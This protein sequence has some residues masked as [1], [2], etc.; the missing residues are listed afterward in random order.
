MSP[1]LATGWIIC[2]RSCRPSGGISLEPLPAD[3]SRAANGPGPRAVPINLASG[4]ST[5]AAASRLE[6]G[7]SAWSTENARALC[8]SPNAPPQAT[9]LGLR[10]A[11]C[12]AGLHFAPMSTWAGAAFCRAKS[13]LQNLFE[14]KTP[15]LSLRLTSFGSAEISASTRTRPART[16]HHWRALLLFVAP[17]CASAG[18]SERTNMHLPASTTHQH[19]EGVQ[20]HALFAHHP[21]PAPGRNPLERGL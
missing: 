3:K 19:A 10:R 20:L 2:G 18:V 8:L 13:A 21:A 1:S 12:A 16:P 11:P 6:T 9:A 15:S 7:V 14:R 4:K 5:T 17:C